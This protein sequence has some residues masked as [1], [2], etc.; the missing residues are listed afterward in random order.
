MLRE[1]KSYSQELSTCS[2]YVPLCTSV[3]QCDITQVFTEVIKMGLNTTS[4]LI[5][6]ENLDTDTHTGRTPREEEGRD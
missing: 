3:P 1:Q 6:G 5:R 2:N 4:I